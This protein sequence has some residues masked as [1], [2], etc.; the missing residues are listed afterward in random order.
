MAIRPIK[1]LVKAKPTTEAKDALRVLRIAVKL[2]EP[3]P[4]DLLHGD[5]AP[6]LNGRPVPDNS[7]DISDALTIL[8]KTVGFITL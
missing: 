1:R 5:V 7:I 6:Y 4:A 2:V 8:R 3:T